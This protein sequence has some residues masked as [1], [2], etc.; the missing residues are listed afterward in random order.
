MAPPSASNAPT[1]RQG[2]MSRSQPRLFLY[3]M[4][5]GLV[6]VMVPLG[7]VLPW[8]EPL[9]Y[10]PPGV[11]LAIGGAALAALAAGAWSTAVRD[12]SRGLVMVIGTVTYA[13]F[14]W[15]AVQHHLG[16]DDVIGLIPAALVL[17]MLVER[18]GEFIGAV[19][20]TV[21]I[22][23]GVA[24][25]TVE[26]VFP[27]ATFVAQLTTLAL[28][29]GAQSL[30]RSRAEQ[31]LGSLAADLEQRVQARTED[32]SHALERAEAETRER[33]I[34]EARALQA[35]RAKS[36]FFARLS[37]ELRTPLNAVHGYAG[38]VHDD[39][40]GRDGDEQHNLDDLERIQGAS[41]TL[42]GLLDEMLEAT[43]VESD[44]LQLTLAP[45][46][47][48][49]VLE[50]ALLPIEAT[51]P[52]RV[53]DPSDL[54]VRADAAGLTDVIRQLVGN[55]VHVATSEVRILGVRDGERIGLQVHD[56]GP[57]IEGAGLDG[58]FERH[59]DELPLGTA[60]GLARCRWLIEGMGGHLEVA[61]QVGAGSTFTVW[62]LAA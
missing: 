22:A 16:H 56:D 35:S 53:A 21:G 44:E 13:W 7:G 39:L 62:L 32:L 60:L 37:H 14:A 27:P 58:F 34:A 25:L 8:S 40:E 4:V 1:P 41:R 61:S 5:L 48:S 10:D 47:L 46:A 31:A 20:I 11:R 17:P 49:G 59:L 15:V 19:L 9:A 51:S 23:V 36:R 52:L 54:I 33:R 30:S 18:R 38:L 2:V 3:R 6:A 55:A 43:R 45:V 29:L 42:L 12:A 50:H 26:P 24:W 57:G 28:A